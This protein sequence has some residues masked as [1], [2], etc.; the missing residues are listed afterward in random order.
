M[1]M[2]CD[3][4]LIRV[5]EVMRRVF[6]GSLTGAF[7][8][9]LELWFYEFD[10]RHGIAAVLS[11]A[12]FGSALGIFGP[13]IAKGI[14]TALIFC[15]TVGGLAGALW[16]V[17]AKPNVNV[18]LSIGVGAVLGIFFVLGEGNWKMKKGS[19]QQINQGDGE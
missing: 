2:I 10:L 4:M 17:I 1:G 3:P 19:V 6:L 8:G 9:G 11:G 14:K 5:K 7:I 13:S 18:L 15:A 16:W 12:I